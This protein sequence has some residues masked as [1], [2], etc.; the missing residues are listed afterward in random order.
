MLGMWH[1]PEMVP[2]SLMPLGVVD[3]AP[4]TWI[5]VK[6]PALKTKPWRNPPPGLKLPTI[7]P[8]LLMPLLAVLADPGGSKLVNTYCEAF[9]ASA[10][11]AS[12]PA[13]SRFRPKWR[14]SMGGLLGSR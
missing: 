9:W 5:S 2:A 7:V 12:T 14:R 4:G 11:E 8:A 1:V 10:G 13:A 6:P 3:T